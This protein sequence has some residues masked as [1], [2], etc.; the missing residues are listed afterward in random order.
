MAASVLPAGSATVA[1]HGVGLARQRPRGPA[2]L[3]VAQRLDRHHRVHTA[4]R[5]RKRLIKRHRGG[6]GD[7]GARFASA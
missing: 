2:R 5:S 6:L 1:G 7:C 4:G 3:E